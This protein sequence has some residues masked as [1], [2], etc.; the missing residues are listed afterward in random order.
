MSSALKSLVATGTKLWLDSIDPD[1]VEQNYKMGATGATSNPIIIADL[2]NT[3][4]FDQLIK[5]FM[6]LEYSDEEVAW[7][8]TDQM[9]RNIQEVF[10]PIWEKTQGND[11]YVSFELDPLLEDAQCPLSHQE[12]VDTYIKL[13]LKWSQSQH[14]NNRMIK[15]PATPAGLDAI[16]EIAAAGITLNVTLIFSQRQYD[17]ARDAVW[18]GRQRYGKL[19]SFKSVYSIFISRIDVYTMKHVTQLS[20]QAQGQVG[21]YN[22]KKIARANQ[23][24]WADKNLKLEQEIIFASTG[25]KLAEDPKDKYV[26]AFAGR[27]IQTNPPATNQAVEEL[28]T[29]FTRCIDIMPHDDIIAEIEKHVDIPALEKTLMAEGLAKFAD[30]Q[31]SL[32]KLIGEKRSVFQSAN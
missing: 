11:G 9:V 32:I 10:T 12:K 6:A 17:L 19:D 25:T 18:R 1:L 27:Y 24:F 21:I 16:E 3:G 22:A 2:I 14:V 31:K 26:K 5:D 20:D 29:Q 15:I 13:A 7:A 30:P 4:R 23:S 28:G 8:T